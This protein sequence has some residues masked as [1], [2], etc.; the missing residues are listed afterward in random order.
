MKTAYLGGNVAGEVVT[1]KLKNLQRPE[2]SDALGDLAGEHVVRKGQ[3]DDSWGNVVVAGDAVPVAVMGGGGPAGKEVGGVEGDRVL[4]AQKRQCV[5]TSGSRL[6]E[7][8]FICE[9]GEN[10]E[11][12]W[13]RRHS[14]VAAL[15]LENCYSSA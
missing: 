10:D 11:Q 5:M 13:K 12:P 8:E 2:L 14:C 1:L 4:E 6:G 9:R 15:L 3:G 7:S